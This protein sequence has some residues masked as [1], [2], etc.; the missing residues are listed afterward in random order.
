MKIFISSINVHNEADLTAILDNAGYA[1]AL[2]RTGDTTGILDIRDHAFRQRAGIEES[3]VM[4]ML[5][6]LVYFEFNVTLAQ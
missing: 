4:E 2:D 3:A 5:S 6:E 1:N